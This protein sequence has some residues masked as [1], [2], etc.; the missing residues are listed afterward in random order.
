[1][2]FSDNLKRIRTEKGIKQ[3]ELAQ[4]IKM[5]P[6]HVSRYERGE[7]TPSADIV[8]SFAEVLDVSAD[9]LL[10]GNRKE[11]MMDSIKDNELVKLF[12]SVENLDEKEKATVKDLIEAFLFRNETRS[13]LII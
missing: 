6:N 5:H 4:K 2:S 13:R 7:S 1:M 3:N 8:K 10:F 11:Y 12:K 9:Q